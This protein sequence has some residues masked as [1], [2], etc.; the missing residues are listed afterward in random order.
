MGCG[1]G[2]ARSARGRRVEGSLHLVGP[3]DPRAGIA[4]AGCW[5]GWLEPVNGRFCEFHLQCEQSFPIECIRQLLE[6]PQ[7]FL[8][9]LRVGRQL[10]EEAVALGRGEEV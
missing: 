3:Q 9:A 10:G 5:L 2:P 8:R 1:R 7:R 6:L 4:L